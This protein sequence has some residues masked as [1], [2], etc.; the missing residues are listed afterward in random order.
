M[1]FPERLKK[2]GYKYLAALIL[3]AIVGTAPRWSRAAV[4]QMAYFHVR[5]IEI[6]GARYLQP[7]DIV[8]RLRVDTLRSIVDDVTPLV[9]RLK[10]HPQIAE[11]QITRRLPGTLVVTITENLPVALVPAGDGLQP[12]DS[13]GHAL[14]IDPA[15]IPMDLPIVRSSPRQAAGAL[16][17][18]GAIRSQEPAVFARISE[19]IPDSGGELLFVL[20]PDLHVRT[21]I[22][23]APV[24]FR[25]IFPVEADLARRQERPVELDLRYRDQVVARLP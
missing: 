6:R 13:A 7:T 1:K 23:V 15:R 19:V 20:A 10:D 4:R 3:L 11:A 17:T 14:P 8:A 25:D 12:F 18:L 2:P 22:G 24:R 5:T 16:R 21:M 9:S